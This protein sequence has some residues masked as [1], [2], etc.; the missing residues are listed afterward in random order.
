MSQSHFMGVA[1]WVAYLSCFK[2]MTDIC[3]RLMLWHRSLY[4]HTCA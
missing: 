2:C 4:R 3:K 1:M